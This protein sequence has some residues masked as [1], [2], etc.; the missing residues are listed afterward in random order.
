MPTH[1]QTNAMKEQ[2]TFEFKIKYHKKEWAIIE[3]TPV[4][5][6]VAIIEYLDSLVFR[7]M[8]VA[9]RIR[10]SGSFRTPGLRPWT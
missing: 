7:R 6:T 10:P 8:T 3:L 5:L 1:R 4:P 9:G 2:A